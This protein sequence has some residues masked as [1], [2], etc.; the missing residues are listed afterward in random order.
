MFCFIFDIVLFLGFLLTYDR[1]DDYFFPYLCLTIFSM[2]IVWYI[3]KIIQYPRAV[4]LVIHIM[5]FIYFVLYYI[6]F[7]MAI[8]F[9]DFLFKDVTRH[10]NYNQETLIY[11]F[12]ILT[13]SFSF[14]CIVTRIV[15]SD[16]RKKERMLFVES[17]KLILVNKSKYNQFVINLFLVCVVLMIWSSYMVMTSGIAQMGSEKITL[18]GKMAGIIMNVRQTV[19]PLILFLLFFWANHLKDSKTTSLAVILMFVHGIGEL[20]L[21]TSKNMLVIVTIITLL[22]YLV[23]NKNISRRIKTVFFLILLAL[24]ILYPFT[25]AYRVLKYTNPDIGIPDVLAIMVNGS[26]NIS[27]D[28]PLLLSATGSLL[29]RGTGVEPLLD[30]VAAGVGDKVEFIGIDALLKSFSNVDVGEY[31]TRQVHGITSGL[32]ASATGYL[33]FMYIIGGLPVVVLITVTFSYIFLNLWIAIWSSDHISA[34]PFL[35]LSAVY[36][37]HMYIIDGVFDVIYLSNIL[38]FVGFILIAYIGEILTRRLF[39]T[40]VIA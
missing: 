24:T 28:E 12:F 39:K 20:L 36:Y 34:K 9:T 31:F 5:L 18:P 32:H 14:F 17:T 37:F 19:I 11:S 8:L 40:T 13:I 4:S 33:G 27:T 21:R 22:L 15:F 1:I 29:S 23:I 6:K 35:M 3:R 26:E 30:M 38:K 10:Y 16:V 7:Y 25:Q 2:S